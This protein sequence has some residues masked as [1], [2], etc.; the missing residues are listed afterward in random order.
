MPKSKW[1]ALFAQALD[2]V[3]CPAMLQQYRFDP[4]RKWAFDFAH[5]PTKVALEIDGG[6]FVQGAHNRGTR[7]AKDYEKRNHAI[8]QGWIIFQLTGQMVKKDCVYWAVKVKGLI[9][10]G[11]TNSS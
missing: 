9:E 11:R 3:G 10:A 2:A 1:E 7:M 8:M 6:E 5:L 4:T